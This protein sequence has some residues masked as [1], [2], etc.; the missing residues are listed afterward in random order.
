MSLEPRGQ[1]PLPQ[2]RRDCPPMSVNEGSA[3]PPAF[4]AAPLSCWEL[5]ERRGNQGEYQEA[6]VPLQGG[7]K[8]VQ[9]T[10]I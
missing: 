3:F 8:T 5:K 4:G 1:F 7:G 10:P 2:A 6:A 9:K